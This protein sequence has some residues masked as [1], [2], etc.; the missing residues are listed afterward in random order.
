MLL[1]AALLGRLHPHNTEML[2]FACWGRRFQERL[3][4]Y[5]DGIPEEAQRVIDEELAK[6]GS[7]EPSSSEFNVTRN[8]LDWLSSIPW[9]VAS[10][11]RLDIA[12]AQQVGPGFMLQCHQCFL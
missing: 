1:C 11:E 7:L 12:H 3:Q 9:G 4:Q 5:G 6:L 10:T 2:I 8:Y